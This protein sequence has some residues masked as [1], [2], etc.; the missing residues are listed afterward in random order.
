VEEWERRTGR[1]LKDDLYR[2]DKEK[3]KQTEAYRK[4]QQEMREIR[5][6]S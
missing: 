2:R 3:L 5:G 1:K 4:F 6:G